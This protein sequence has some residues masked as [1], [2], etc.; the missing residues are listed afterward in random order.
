MAS[1]IIFGEFFKKMRL[2]QGKPL[3]SFC[4][5][6][7][8]DPGNISKLERGKLPPPKSRVKLEEYATALGLEKGSD[9]WYQFFDLASACKGQIPEELLSDEE[10]LKALPVLFRTLQGQKLSEKKLKELI[11]IIR[12]A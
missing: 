5:E 2:Q 4:I 3:R 6:N 9:D 11:E 10:T 1:N 7:G 8:F 12:K